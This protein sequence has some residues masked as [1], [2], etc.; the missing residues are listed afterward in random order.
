MM[1]LA[2]RAWLVVVLLLASIGTAS[3]ECAWVLWWEHGNLRKMEW[4]VEYAT[5]TES[6]CR[7]RAQQRYEAAKAGH[8]T[9]KQFG[10]RAA[11]D[12]VYY[13]D[14]NLSVGTAAKDGSRIHD[15][16]HC[17]PDTIDP[18]GRK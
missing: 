6:A 17:F 10:S 2:R 11:D 13:D 8:E 12:R 15:E 4:I 14:E 7:V 3:A 5:S 18:R 9:W 1:Q 16:F